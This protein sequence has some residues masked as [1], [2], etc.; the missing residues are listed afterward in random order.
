[1]ELVYLL[2]SS[3]LTNKGGLLIVDEI[4]INLPDE[5]DINSPIVPEPDVINSAGA[6]LSSNIINGAENDIA[7]EI[8][9]AT[10]IRH[11]FKEYC[12][13]RIF[14]LRRIAA[15]DDCRNAKDRDLWIMY[16]VKNARQEDRAV[17]L[18]AFHR[19]CKTVPQGCP[20]DATKCCRYPEVYPYVYCQ[21]EG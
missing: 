5:I 3:E 11:L 14:I 18:K 20:Q 7:S 16:K 10:K 2:G 17:H 19:I 13:Q 15:A 8:A 12:T 6:T 1:M 9:A 4:D 21:E